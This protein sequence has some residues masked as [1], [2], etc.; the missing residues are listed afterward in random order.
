MSETKTKVEFTPGPWKWF[1]KI[2]DKGERIQCEDGSM[3]FLVGSDG[4]GFAHTV[5]LSSEGVDAA[6]AALIAAAP[7][8]Y[9]ALN[10]FMALIESEDVFIRTKSKELDEQREKA[11]YDIQQA[12]SKASPSR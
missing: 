11:L 7:C 2:T 12:L 3:K 9:Q 5:G 4:Q 8:L 10:N 6:N 1:S